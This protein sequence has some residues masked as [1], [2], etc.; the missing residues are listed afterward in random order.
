MAQEDVREAKAETARVRLEW[1]ELQH[2][3]RNEER[4]LREAWQHERRQ[5]EL[6]R[7][8]GGEAERDEARAELK[9]AAQRWLPR[10]RSGRRKDRS[11]CL[12]G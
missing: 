9:A 3:L 10:T 5:E 11:L 12:H 2:K 4:Q 1:N 6:R 8:E 7:I